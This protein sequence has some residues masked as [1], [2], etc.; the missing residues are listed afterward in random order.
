MY[1]HFIISVSIV[2]EKKGGGGSRYYFCTTPHTK[3]IS[4][5]YEEHLP[6]KQD[7]ATGFEL[8]LYDTRIMN[9]GHAKYGGPVSPEKTLD[10]KRATLK[11]FELYH[12][13]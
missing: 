4:I 5:S 13:T 2:P 11:N 6:Q 12:L 10:P 3:Q 7:S 9:A 8:L 1:V